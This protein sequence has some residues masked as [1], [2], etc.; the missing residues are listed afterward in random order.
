MINQYPH[1]IRFTTV[2]GSV[3]DGNGDWTDGTPSTVERAC[4]AEPN[5][6]NG[7][8]VVTDGERIDYSWDV[9]LPLPAIDIAPGTQVQVLKGAKVLCSDTV[10]QYSEGQLN[11]RIWL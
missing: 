4:R 8:V 7:K 11:Q 3:Q 5:S 9:Y 6:G 1:T 2:S 10:K